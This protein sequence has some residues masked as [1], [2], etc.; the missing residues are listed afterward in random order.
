[1]ASS[2][3]TSCF[4]S[5]LF[6]PQQNIIHA[7][8]IAR[9]ILSHAVLPNRFF[10]LT[11]KCKLLGFCFSFIP[12]NCKGSNLSALLFLNFPWLFCPSY[13]SYRDMQSKSYCSKFFYTQNSWNNRA[14][15]K[16]HLACSHCWNY[17]AIPIASDFLS[18]YSLDWNVFFMMA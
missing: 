16:T 6:N 15:F 11:N 1:M 4:S 5:S 18:S 12:T 7:V 17:L 14:G 3:E 13:V 9:I 10:S 2:S 8:L